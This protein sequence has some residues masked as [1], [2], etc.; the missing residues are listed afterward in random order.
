MI[1]RQLLYCLVPALVVV[2]ADT[3]TTTVQDA[4]NTATN[5]AV[6]TVTPSASSTSSFRP[7]WKHKVTN[8]MYSG[9]CRR[10]PL[11]LHINTL[12]LLHTFLH[13]LNTLL[14]IINTDLYPDS[15]GRPKEI[16]FI[17][18]GNNSNSSRWRLLH[19]PGPNLLNSGL[20]LHKTA[21]PPSSNGP[22]YWW[23]RIGWFRYSPPYIA[24]EHSPTTYHVPW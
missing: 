9:Q 18:N 13:I 21:Q 1:L 15:F 12:H 23:R 5:V 17:K 10:S 6:V 3:Q 14:N 19:R 11:N 2:R 7:L 24:T 16:S 4:T 22:L 8:N 20:H